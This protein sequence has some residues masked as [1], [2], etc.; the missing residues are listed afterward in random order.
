MLVL[1][2]RK[3]S[4]R[5][6]RDDP[7]PR[8]LAFVRASLVNSAAVSL[9]NVA[10]RHARRYLLDPAQLRAFRD[11]A[12]CRRN[13]ALVSAARARGRVLRLL[14]LLARPRPSESTK[15]LSLGGLAQRCNRLHSPLSFS[16]V[17]SFVRRAD[18]AACRYACS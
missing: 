5:R 18:S 8:P 13:Y 12:V 7:P 1:A 3:S 10:L 17:E 15:I 16:Q 14:L 9:E 2:A 6:S 11:T 4:P